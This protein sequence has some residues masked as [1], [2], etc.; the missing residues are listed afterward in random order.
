MVQA[1]CTCSCCL[2]AHHTVLV[3][4]DDWHVWLVY[5]EKG[6]SDLMFSWWRNPASEMKLSLR[7]LFLNEVGKQ[8]SMLV[9]LLSGYLWVLALV[10]DCLIIGNSL[11]GLPL[12]SMLRDLQ[13]QNS[14][15][16]RL[17]SIMRTLYGFSPAVRQNH[18]HTIV[19]YWKAT[20]FYFYTSLLPFAKER[21]FLDPLLSSTNRETSENS[22]GY[23][24]VTLH[25]FA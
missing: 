4:R 24:C 1:T 22:T 18:A 5:W 11:I 12:I 9:W 25:K 21:T 16:N 2:H 23:D 19:M 20:A 14:L 17:P 15:G 3:L 7:F 6:P 13:N 8:H 10:F